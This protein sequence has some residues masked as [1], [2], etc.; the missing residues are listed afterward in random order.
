MGFPTIMPTGFLMRV[1]DAFAGTAKRQGEVVPDTADGGTGDGVATVK[2]GVVTE[3]TGLAG[4]SGAAQTL[5][6]SA[7]PKT[8]TGTYV[9]IIAAA[10]VV[11]GVA[12][13]VYKKGT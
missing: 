3:G 4:G 2:G 9:A 12:V 13:Y 1:Q 8:S 10:L 5:P 7:Q 6:K 11:I